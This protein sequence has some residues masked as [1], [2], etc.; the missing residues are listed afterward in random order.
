M[1]QLSK[2]LDENDQSYEAKMARISTSFHREWQLLDIERTKIRQKWDDYFKDFDVL[3][4]PAFRIAAFQHDRTNKLQRVNKFNGQD[5]NHLDLMA[6]WASLAG[7]S[8]LPAT[9][10]PAGITSGGLPVG[11]QI[12]G[13]YLEDRTPIHV[14]KLMEE[15]LGGFTPPPEFS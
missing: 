12:I 14:A 5:K 10:A 9:I 6:P 13:P 15:T 11:I 2:T 7:I 1:L 3:L 4:S 8:H